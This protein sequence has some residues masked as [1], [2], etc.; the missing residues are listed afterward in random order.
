MQNVPPE[1]SLKMDLV[2]HKL[3]LLLDDSEDSMNSKCLMMKLQSDSSVCVTCFA[4]LWLALKGESVSF[5]VADSL[6]ATVS[7]SGVLFF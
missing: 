2:E 3:K 5:P 4:I 7:L 1:A 6:D